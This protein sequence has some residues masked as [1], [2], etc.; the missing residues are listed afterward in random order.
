MTSVNTSDTVT[1]KARIESVDANQHENAIT[2]ISSDTVCELNLNI[3]N[4]SKIQ[5]VSFSNHANGQLVMD[6]KNTS[7]S[8]ADLME[9][10]V[11]NAIGDFIRDCSDELNSDFE[12]S[13]S[14]NSIQNQVYTFEVTFIVVS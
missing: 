1:P 14:D 13:I 2:S 5:S 10:E 6:A 12:N 9:T 3:S 11:Q 4:E 7:N 8:S